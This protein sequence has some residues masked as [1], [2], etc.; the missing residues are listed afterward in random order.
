MVRILTFDRKGAKTKRGMALTLTGAR[1]LGTEARRRVPA[2]AL[3]FR[4][5]DV[6]EQR[7]PRGWIA[8]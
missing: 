7:M 6:A 3:A 8:A 2:A 4:A 1:Y 5:T